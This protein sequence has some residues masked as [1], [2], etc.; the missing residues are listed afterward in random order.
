MPRR[1]GRHLS[2]L[3]LVIL[4]GL[5]SLGFP[6]EVAAS[7]WGSQYGDPHGFCPVQSWLPATY[8][9]VVTNDPQVGSNPEQNTFWGTHPSPG[10]DDWYGSWYGDFRGRPGDASGWQLIRRVDYPSHWH[11]NFADWGWAVHG[12]A[13][14]YIAYYNWTFGGQC[15]MG[16]YGSPWPAPYMADV[17]GYPVIDIYVDSVPP[18]DPKPRIATVTPA[19]ISFTWDPVNDRGDGSGADYFVAGMGSYRYWLTVDNGP[20]VQPGQAAA[21]VLLTVAA[22]PADT[23]CAYVVASDRLGNATAA[24]GA[25]GRPGGEPPLP[26]LPLGAESIRVNPTPSGLAG[27]PAWFWLDPAPA[28]VSSYETVAGVEY[29]VTAQPWTADW[30][31]GDGGRLPGADFGTPYP[32]P[33][34]V[35]HAYSAQSEVGYL[36][37]ATLSYRLSWWWRSGASW[38]GPYPMGSQ[39]EAAAGLAYPVRQAQPE[40]LAVT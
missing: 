36:V 35:Q 9:T 40:L 38:V 5:S 33:P 6:R 29:R 26:P 39:V 32:G 16:W 21:P 7:A 4:A 17:V 37:A 12:H 24:Q 19:S 28:T 31:F 1:A 25:C 30:D 15:G 23:V 18:E 27:L 2:V 3:L 13:K 11:W 22:T 10:Y 34:S 20:P 8:T 14:Q